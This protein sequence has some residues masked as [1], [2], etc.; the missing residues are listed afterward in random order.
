MDNSASSQDTVQ[1]ENGPDTLKLAVE[2]KKDDH[3]T[4]LFV[5]VGG[6]EFKYF[7]PVFTSKE[8][9]NKRL[10]VVKK[11]QTDFDRPRPNHIPED[12]W[13][14]LQEQ[15]LKGLSMLANASTVK[16]PLYMGSESRRGYALLMDVQFQERQLAGD[17]EGA[18]ETTDK[19]LSELLAQ[20]RAELQVLE[21]Q[22]EQRREAVIQ[23]KASQEK[24]SEK[25]KQNDQ[26]IAELQLRREATKSQLQ[27]V[28]KELNGSDVPDTLPNGKQ[29]LRHQ[30]GLEEKQKYSRQES[31]DFIVM[32][33]KNFR[34]HTQRWEKEYKKQYKNEPYN[35]ESESL[36]DR[37]KRLTRL[38]SIWQ[39]RERKAFIKIRARK[40]LE[41]IG[42]QLQLTQEAIDANARLD[43]A[44]NQLNSIRANIRTIDN[45]ES[46]FN[47]TAV[48]IQ[49]EAQS[50]ESQHKEAQDA[51]IFTNTQA[52]ER[53]L[54]IRRAEALQNQK[55]AS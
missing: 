52:Q 21:Q 24:N 55:Q 40:S 48:Q 53:R 2:Q 51:M 44:I 32:T 33:E 10:E 4:T 12:K 3:E 18:K 8:D 35:P 14:E 26:K 34:G 38:Q 23:I 20:D 45:D 7:K 28:L 25:K 9:W 30:E 42:T 50:L 17:L 13:K 15:R 54:R 37:M 5:N 1:Y 36:Q 29:V 49:A 31:K 43:I 47:Q 27:S 16:D 22:Y 6:K 39:E 46:Q 41:L 19:S 11:T